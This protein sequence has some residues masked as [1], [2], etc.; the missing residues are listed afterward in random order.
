MKIAIYW[1]QQ[2]VGG[3]E[4]H[5]LTLLKNWPEKND[6]IVL[7]SHVN[8]PAFKRIANDL[9]ELG[10]VQNVSFNLV[11]F[12]SYLQKIKKVPFYNFFKLLGY[13]CKPLF[14]LKGIYN[15]RKLFNKFGHFDAILSDNGCY[16]GA[17]GCLAAI[18]AAKK[19]NIKKRMLLI[20]HEATKPE[21]F[22]GTF[23]HIIDR[24]ICRSATDI[25]AVSQATRES[26][27]NYRWFDTCINPIRVIYNGVDIFFQSEKKQENDLRKT[28]SLGESTLVGIV[29]RIERYKGH[30][31]L[32]L[33]VSLLS[34]EDQAKIKLVFIGPGDEDEIERLQRIKNN[35]NLTNDLL[36]TGYIP[37][38]PQEIIAQLDMLAVVS[39]NFEGFGLTLAEAMSV[40]VPVLATNIGGIPEF[41]HED[42]GTLVPPESPDQ[43]AERIT[44]FIKFPKK[45][46]LKAEK[47]KLHIRKYSGKKMARKFHQLFMI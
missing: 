2:D 3:V 35:V 11:S 47:A 4:T 5:L 40:G 22:W 38:A 24:L 29:G 1:E 30:E 21:I 23:E 41:I 14:F 13:I 34:K 28:Y 6:E 27:I 44:D 37:G 7:F 46:Q 26:I 9:A 12:S 32:I 8:D 42:V 19:S 20:H 36:F 39:K 31:D 16:P 33:G 15:C 18:I 43:V 25:V 17:S 10:Y 45:F